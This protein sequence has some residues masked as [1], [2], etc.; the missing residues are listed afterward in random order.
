MTQEIKRSDQLQD[1]ES[2]KSI[3]KKAEILKWVLRCLCLFI[4]V[5]QGFDAVSTFM[6]LN[7]G[8]LVEKNVLLSRT[9]QL[10]DTPIGNVVLVSKIV[11]AV[12]FGWLML[13]Q[14]PTLNAVV[15]LFLVAAFYVTVVQRN[16]YWVSIVNAIHVK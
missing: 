8:H 10:L 5:L 6:A 14:K 3:Q 7:T 4:M 16:F 2:E 13:K 15:V 11:V 9:A 12:L 1:A